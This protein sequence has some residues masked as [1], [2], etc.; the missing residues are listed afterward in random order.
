M[1]PKQMDDLR[2]EIA[3]KCAAQLLASRDTAAIAAS[4]S[5]GRRRLRTEPT[6]IG[7]GT[8][9][10][11]LGVDE[12]G[13]LAG[14]AF[15]DAVDNGAPFRHIREVIARGDFDL[16]DPLAQAMVQSL[17]S[18]E[19]GGLLTQAQADALCALGYQPDPVSE[20]EVRVACY[21]ADGREWLA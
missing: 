9:L 8:I 15:L 2:A 13:E 3:G 11:V 14:N 12:Q 7:K 17:T 1:T 6:H 20:L 10:A 21:A 19:K 4:V 16:T 5:T 18:Q